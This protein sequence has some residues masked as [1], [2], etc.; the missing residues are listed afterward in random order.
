[1]DTDLTN[2]FSAYEE[3]DNFQITSSYYEID[4]LSKITLNT[5]FAN[6]LSIL[7]L[8]ICS[9]NSK[10][11]NLSNLL[12]NFHKD[13]SVINLQEIWSISKNFCLPGYQKLEYSSRDKY[14]DYLNPNCGGGI[15]TFIRE[16][17]SY[18]ILEV[19]D[20]FIT[21]VFES[22]WIKIKTKNNKFK[23]IGNI[24]RPNTTPTA[25]PLLAINTLNN[26]LTSLKSKFKGVNITIS[27][28]LN[29]DLL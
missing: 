21:G 14:A 13:F 22:L 26:I 4:E 29:F 6:V 1:M 2:L 28:D 17:L 16:G 27:G 15:G 11:S 23:I 12:H 25:D 7:S 3:S 24:Y 10:F 5:E 8:N 18:E 19:K 9:L 20:Q